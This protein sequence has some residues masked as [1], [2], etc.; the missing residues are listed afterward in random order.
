MG[1]RPHKQYSLGYFNLLRGLGTLFV[2]VGHSAAL[3]VAAKELPLTLPVFR[4]AG[5]VLG[6]GVMSMFFMISGFYYYRRTPARCIKS[7]AKILL[8]PYYLTGLAIFVVKALTALIKG[9]P[10]MEYGAGLAFTFLL[11]L[12][13]PYGTEFAGMNLMTVS[14]F[15]FV[16]ALFGGWIIYNFIRW[17]P[18]KQ[19]RGLYILLCILV[20][21]VLT[22]VS[23]VWP[24]AFPMALL[25]VG[26]LCA[27]NQ[28]R[29]RNLLR[30]RLP[31][32]AWIVMW[33]IVLTSMAFGN[34]DIA[35]CV[36]EMGLL[37]VL[38]TFCLGFMVMRLYSSL[39]KRRLKGAFVRMMEN[40]GLN[41]IWILCL[42][43]FEKAVI[44]WDR[45]KT[46]FPDQPQLCTAVCFFGR[47][48]VIFVLYMAIFRI[49]KLIRRRRR[50][51]IV[52]TDEDEEI[53]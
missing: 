24:Y 7:Q 39:T 6:A 14:I 46:I 2:I 13:A 15:W 1:K 37:D 49:R 16:L 25:A 45:L 32:F 43:A 5:R 22:E 21:W 23:K 19:I 26:Y 9:Q 33:I 28:I 17:I 50:P 30:R 18:D 8:K 53:L 4:G 44:P 3:F 20:S 35:A 12:N 52:I 41:S 42:H 10:F 40:V 36:W 27:G 51:V 31:T 47:C 34:V 48:L 11:G 38:A 29:K